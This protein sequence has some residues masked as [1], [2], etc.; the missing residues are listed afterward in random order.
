MR[1]DEKPGLRRLPLFREMKTRTFDDLMNIA[2]VQMFPPQLELFRHGQ[3]ADFL[4]VII[5]GSVEFHASWSGRETVMG[6]ARPISAFIL[7]ACIRDAPYLM[8]ARTLE[9]S[10]IVLLPAAD[11]RAAMRN[12]AGFAMAA[13]NELANSFRGMVLQAKNLKLRTA[14][15]RLAAWILHH[16]GNEASL[17][18]PFGKRH[19]ASYLG[20]APE[21]LSRTIRALESDGIKVDGARVIITDR[22]AL[23]RVALPEPSMDDR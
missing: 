11:L 8:S 3:M 17:V 6:V 19:L 20:I 22:A 1:E 9:A 21:S 18:L 4:H 14:R 2:Y 5:E 13:L 16:A 12:D 10:R 15:E 23:T 7:A